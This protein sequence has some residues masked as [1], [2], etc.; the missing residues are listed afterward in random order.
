MFDLSDDIPQFAMPLYEVRRPKKPS[1]GRRP[2]PIPEHDPCPC[3]KPIY[4]R[5]D[6]R[7]ADYIARRHCDHSCASRL[8][9]PRSRS[10]AWEAAINEHNPCPIC[11]GA[12]LPR[13]ARE[14]LS[15]YKERVT[16]GSPKCRKAHRQAVCGRA[17]RSQPHV[18][19][20]FMPQWPSRTGILEPL[21]FGDQNLRLRSTG[22]MRTIER[23]AVSS[24]SASAAAI[25][26]G[27]V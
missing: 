23:P 6:E 13:D 15:R 5:A 25:T 22:S 20:D 19:P 26:A 27:L 17:P 12:V 8:A 18:D 7:L 14:P 9:N 3:G 21:S 24:P 16:C 11:R 2:K 10:P 1:L 4:R